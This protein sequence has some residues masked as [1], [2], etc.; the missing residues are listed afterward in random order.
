MSSQE[1]EIERLKHTL[2]TSEDI[3]PLFMDPELKELRHYI[4]FTHARMEESVGLAITR[5]NLKDKIPAHPPYTP[6]QQS[7]IYAGT[8]S[9]IEHKSYADKVQDASTRFI[10]LVD[11]QTKITLDRVNVLRNAFGH[12]SIP[13]FRDILTEL[14]NDRSKY[15]EAL[16][17]L[18]KA[19][20]GMNAIALKSLGTQS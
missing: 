3:D 11:E 20:D 14:K 13:K 8:V 15:K 18:K 1:E 6:E 4:L 19:H 17:D 9:L 2:Q 10:P 12:P 16:E 5:D 7:M